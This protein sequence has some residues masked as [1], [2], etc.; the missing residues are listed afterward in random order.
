IQ[1]A[2]AKLEKIRS[3]PELVHA[4][5]LYEQTR[6]D[7]KFGIQGA[8]LEERQGIARNLKAMGIPAPQIAQGTGLSPDEI[9]KL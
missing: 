2:Q 9:A 6:I 8:R 7:Y 5:D 1:E 3:D 4:Y